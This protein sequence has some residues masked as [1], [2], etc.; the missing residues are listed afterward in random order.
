MKNRKTLHKKLEWRKNKS[1]IL[2]SDIRLNDK[3]VIVVIMDWFTKIIKL[4][5]A[6]T[7]V[8]SKEITKIYRDNIWKI[9]RVSRKILSNKGSQLTLQFMED[10]SKILGTKQML[11]IA[12]HSQTNGQT[13]NQ[14]NDWTKWLLV[15][16]FQYNKKLSYRVYTIWA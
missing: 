10:L 13:E 5:V 1:T 9:H 6:I 14:Q 7:V 3:N 12:Y 2:A 11:S 16:E 15:V 8:S 4:R